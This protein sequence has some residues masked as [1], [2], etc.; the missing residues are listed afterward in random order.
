MNKYQRLKRGDALLNSGNAEVVRSD[1]FTLYSLVM[2][3]KA[4]IGTSSN[5]F[6]W[7]TETISSK[8]TSIRMDHPIILC[9]F[10]NHVFS[11][12]SNPD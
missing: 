3:G 7:N 4:S 1:A 8:E 12:H 10:I 6:M 11:R 2:L 5:F 9:F